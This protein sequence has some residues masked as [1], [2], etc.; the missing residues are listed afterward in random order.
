M[1]IGTR[2]NE[3]KFQCCWESLPWM[4][5][6]CFCSGSTHAFVPSFPRKLKGRFKVKNAVS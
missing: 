6:I 5:Q 3:E 1:M 4:G 2:K